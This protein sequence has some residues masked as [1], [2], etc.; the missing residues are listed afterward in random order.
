VD[1]SLLDNLNIDEPITHNYS[2]IED[3]NTIE[4]AGWVTFQHGWF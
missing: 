2:V 4:L 1:R 3:K